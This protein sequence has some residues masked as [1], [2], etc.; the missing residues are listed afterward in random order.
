M[1]ALPSWSPRRLA[2]LC[3][4]G[5]GLSLSLLRPG[6]RMPS[7]PIPDSPPGVRLLAEDSP[8]HD[9]ARL[10][11]PARLILPPVLP[12]AGGPEA[13][14]PEVVPFPPPQADSR[15]DVAGGLQLGLGSPQV[16]ESLPAAVQLLEVPFP[17]QSLGERVG[18]ALPAS[19]APRLRAV[20]LENGIVYERSLES[21]LDKNLSISDL[22]I[23]SL[24]TFALGID[25]FGLQAPP[26]LLVGTGQAAGDEAAIRWA[27]RQ[28]WATWLPPGSYR[29]EITP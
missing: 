12:G 16:A 6:A 5:V 15:L 7:P 21:E 20:A 22:G 28:P 25:A 19:R 24:P 13:A 9:R 18:R 27:Q 23:K 17:L 14:T 10:A 11:D 4:A 29:V 2:W 3:L 8:W 26:V 1:P